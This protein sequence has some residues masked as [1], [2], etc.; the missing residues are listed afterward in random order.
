M[1]LLYQNSFTGPSGLKNLKF[2][3]QQ[4]HIKAAVKVNTSLLEFYW[5]LGNDIVGKQKN[6]KW[7][8]GFLQQLSRDLI[9]E[10]PNIKGFFYQNLKHV[11]RWYLIYNKTIPKKIATC[12]P[13]R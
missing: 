1:Y 5:E 11:R 8:S 4:A 6:T 9:S 10:F 12:Y 13:I 7:G 3:F 2:K